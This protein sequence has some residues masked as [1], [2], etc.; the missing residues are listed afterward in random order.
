MMH[1]PERVFDLSLTIL[2]SCLDDLPLYPL[3][4]G[5]GTRP[6]GEGIL[7]IVPM[8]FGKT[9]CDDSAWVESGD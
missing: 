5:R 6:K 9:G 1:S 8:S 4:H 7:Y 3:P 2:A